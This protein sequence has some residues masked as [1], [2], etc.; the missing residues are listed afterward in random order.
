[1]PARE[2]HRLSRPGCQE[3]SWTFY[4][5]R[6]CSENT[7]SISGGR[8]ACQSRVRLNLISNHTRDTFCLYEVESIISYFCLTDCQLQHADRLDEVTHIIVFLHHIISMGTCRSWFRAPFE[9]SVENLMITQMKHIAHILAIQVWGKWRE[10][11]VASRRQT[12]RD[13]LVDLKERETQ[14]LL[15]R[16]KCQ[17]ER[18]AGP[19]RKGLWKLTEFN[20]L[21]QGFG[22]NRTFIESN[23]ILVPIGPLLSASFCYFGERGFKARLFGRAHGDNINKA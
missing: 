3:M 19:S 12:N 18:A 13:K 8:L 2:W 21:R 1:M 20:S 10:D 4:D 15:L 16:S 11:D 7:I 23:F 17:A 22:E 6:N 5:I 9:D 14:S